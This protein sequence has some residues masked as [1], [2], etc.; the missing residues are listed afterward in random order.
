MIETPTTRAPHKARRLERPGA[1]VPIVV[2]GEASIGRV[3]EA[4]MKAGV[5][6]GGEA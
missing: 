4:L 2:G 6:P 5:R 3:R 1:A